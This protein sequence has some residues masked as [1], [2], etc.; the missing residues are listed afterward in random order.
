MAGPLEI[1]RFLESDLN[2]VTF[3]NSIQSQQL[4]F[5]FFLFEI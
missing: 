1:F 2:Y 3:K 5:S 4:K